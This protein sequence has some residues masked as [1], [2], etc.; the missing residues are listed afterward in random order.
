MA[1]PSCRLLATCRLFERLVITGSASTNAR[2]HSAHTHGPQAHFTTRCIGGGMPLLSSE[3]QS[4]C[5]TFGNHVT[6]PHRNRTW[7]TDKRISGNL[8]VVGVEKVDPDFTPITDQTEGQE[9]SQMVNTSLARGEEGRLFAVVSIKN[10]Q[11]KV[12]V[13]DVLVVD[14]EFAPTVGDR[15]RLEK[16]LLVG[17][18]DFTLLGQPILSR[19]QVRVEATVIEKTLS[20]NQVWSTYKRRK[21]SRKM[22]LFRDPHTMMVIN[23]I[24]VSP[25]PEA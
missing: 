15:I 16:V 20:H 11:R 5:G 21:R 2:F 4:V 12:T 24:E 17:G 22:K 19:E 3:H 18:K 14:T 23:R 6:I 25:V 8:G 13:E 9:L 7:Y 1:V 10:Q